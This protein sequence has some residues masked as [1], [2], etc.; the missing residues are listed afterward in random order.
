[1][2]DEVIARIILSDEEIARIRWIQ[3]GLKMVKTCGSCG[4]R[5]L[6][7][8]FARY[9]ATA[10]AACEDDARPSCLVRLERARVGIGA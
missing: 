6:V 8:E 7:A 2:S 5:K 3:R 1:M 4:A 10:C 9:G